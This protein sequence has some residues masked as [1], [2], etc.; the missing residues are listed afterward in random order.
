MA[1]DEDAVNAHA[2]HEEDVVQQVGDVVAR[3]AER[4][5]PGGGVGARRGQGTRAALAL[6]IGN[7]VV[8]EGS[9]LRLAAALQQIEALEKKIDT[10]SARVDSIFKYGAIVVATFAAGLVNMRRLPA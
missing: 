5:Y 3:L 6:P 4:R 9:D 8:N 7:A 1:D 2:I 10:L